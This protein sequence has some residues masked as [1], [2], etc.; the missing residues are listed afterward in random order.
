[1][2]ISLGT[3]LYCH[4]FSLDFNKALEIEHKLCTAGDEKNKLELYI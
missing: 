3:I 4:Y 1:M 2:F